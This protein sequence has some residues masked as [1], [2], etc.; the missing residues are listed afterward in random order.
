MIDRACLLKAEL[1]YDQ[2]RSGITESTQ[3]TYKHLTLQEALLSMM[4]SFESNCIF[5][6][7]LV[8]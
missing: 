4:Q 8:V 7:T 5:P 6:L 1:L 2:R 3:E